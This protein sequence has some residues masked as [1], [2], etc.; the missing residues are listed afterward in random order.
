[1]TKVIQILETI[2]YQDKKPP[3]ILIV[4]SKIYGF[5]FK[6]RKA[7]FSLGI[8]SSTKPDIPVIVIGNLNIGGTG[9]TPFTL[10]LANTLSRSGKKVGIVT[11]GYLGKKSS[12]T[13][14]IL[15]EDSNAQDFG[16]EAVYLSRH[17]DSIV[18]VCKKRSLAANLLFEQG[19][20]VILSD[21]G[22]QHYALKRDLEF[23]VVS[24]NRAFGNRQLLPAGPLREGLERLD[25][26]DFLLLNGKTID[27]DI[28]TKNMIGFEIANKEV[29]NI[30]NGQ[31]RSIEDFMNCD[32]T[33]IA[34]IGNPDALVKK[35]SKLGTNIHAM[36][37]ADHQK[38]DLSEIK[39]LKSRT[40][41]I[42]PKDL[43]K[44]SKGDFPQ[45]TWE[46]I[47]EMMID[48]SQEEFIMNK[49]IGIIQ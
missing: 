8:L 9:K 7:L 5:L 40:L 25:T 12:S 45:D 46:L 20:D 4:L 23:A 37:V 33:L 22:L 41:F 36:E 10:Y 35:L 38:I 24:S 27:D 48:Q 6:I 34:G 31:V 16:D 17:S 2:W 13:P 19:V 44:Y 26:L 1:M 21:D 43:V 14:H 11:R 47:P 3:L 29:T 49:V 15:D 42:T 28:H 30:H 32:V 18:C 39:N